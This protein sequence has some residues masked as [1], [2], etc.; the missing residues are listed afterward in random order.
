MAFNFGELKLRLDGFAPGMAEAITPIKYEAL[1][2]DL[3]CFLFRTTGA[4]NTDYYF[5]LFSY[6]FVPSLKDAAEIIESW[7]GGKI[8]EF[9]TPVVGK[10]RKDASDSELN[11]FTCDY[12]DT[13]HSLLAMV[14][15]PGGEGYW[16]TNIVIMPGDNIDDKLAGQSDADIQSAKK[17]LAQLINS[18]APKGDSIADAFVAKMQPEINSK[19]LHTNTSNLAISLYKSRSGGWDFFYNPVRSNQK[20]S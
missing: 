18:T 4:D 9:L 7:H 14:E 12:G 8:L 19:D 3:F 11:K 13:Y 5:V 2:P 1:T 16:A 15:R 17:A 10:N 6:D 20:D